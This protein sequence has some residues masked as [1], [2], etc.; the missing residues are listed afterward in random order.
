MTDL[1]GGNRRN[2]AA[3]SIN[4]GDQIVGA[5]LGPDRES[6]SFLYAAGTATV[7]SQA[8]RGRAR[9]INNAGQIAG[10][11]RVDG[12]SANQAFL[13]S[14]GTVIDLGTL[15]GAGSEAHAINDSGQVAGWAHVDGN[16]TVHA[17]LYSGAGLTDLG[18]LGGKNSMAYGID[19]A[20]EVVGASEMPESGV[21]H[22]FLYRQGAMTDL[23]TLG[24]D[25]SQAEGINGSGWIVGWSRT[26]SGTERAILWKT[27]RMV[28]LNSLVSA[29]P[30][31][32]LEDATGINESGQIV[33]NGSNGHA[34]LI[35]LPAP[36]R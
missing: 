4:D 10:D 9:G 11:Q 25:R 24:G 28:D 31:I 15:G 29:G 26:A 16:S 18:T 6:S 33:A 22:A 12:S 36:L 7:L 35:T 34:Y 17:F 3:Y 30:G 32:W 23:G 8:P 2:S 14:A 1:D 13:W 20:G 21:E 27:G 19:G 5:Y